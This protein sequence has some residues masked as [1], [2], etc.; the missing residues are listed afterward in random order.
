VPRSGRRRDDSQSI[1]VFNPKSMNVMK[2]IRAALVALLCC[3]AATADA[4]EWAHRQKI[5]LDATPAGADLKQGAAMVPVPVR[6]HS[7]NFTFADAKPDGSDIRFMA[8][9]GKLPLKFHIEQFDAPNELGVAWVQV[10]KITPNAKTDSLVMEWGNP[11]AP[12]TGDAKGTY[13]ASQIFVLHFADKDGVRD[14]TGNVNH[15]QASTAKPLAAGPMGGAVAF[16]GMESITLPA[17]PSLKITAANGFTFSAWVKPVAAP[18]GKLFVLGSGAQAV[19][20]TFSGGLLWAWAGGGPAKVAS[21]T[22]LAPGV[23]QHVAVSVGGGRVTFY[24]DGKAAGGGEFALADSAGAAVIGAAFKGE[25]DEVGL[26]GV[27]RPADYIRARAIGEAAESPLLVFDDQGGGESASYIGILLGALTLDGWIVIGI[28][29]VMF[30]ISVWVMISKTSFLLKAQRGNDFFVNR[31]RQKSAQLLTPGDPESAVL[32]NEK[33]LR[34]SP[35]YRI[36]TIGLAEIQ[37]RFEHQTR[38]GKTHQLSLAA[39]EAIR[40]SMDAGIVRESQRLNSQIVLLTI[41]ISGGPFL[42][43]L[44]TVVGVMITFAAIAAAGDVNVNSIAPGI[45]AALVATVAGLAVAIPALFGYNWLASKIKEVS[46]DILVFADEFRT[47]SAELYE[48]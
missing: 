46:S 15:A 29:G 27:A 26:S 8:A 21:D 14:A 37:H 33:A 25:M 28:L 5:T 41:A 36:Y 48:P 11:A 24:L 22:P 35:I 3:L 6:L 34:H 30:V 9:D 10:P 45:A 13:D 47:K 4:A 44:G 42:G 17:S 18:E 39:L 23:W 1:T 12:A 38:A 20:I 2:P 40:A 43:L 16:T 7:G 19:S 31:F 32:A